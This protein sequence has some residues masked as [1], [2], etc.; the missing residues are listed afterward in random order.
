MKYYIALCHCCCSWLHVLVG[1]AN[2]LSC[3]FSCLSWGGIAVCMN[4]PPS[5]LPL[6]VNHTHTQTSGFLMLPEEG[7]HPPSIHPGCCFVF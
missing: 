5:K 7:G 2:R 6:V 1:H 3:C 4:F